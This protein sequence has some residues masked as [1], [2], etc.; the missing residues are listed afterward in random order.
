M[1]TRVRLFSF[2]ALVALVALAFTPAAS[3]ISNDC[4]LKCTPGCPC[5]IEC[6]LVFPTTCGEAGYAC[7]GFA[8]APATD[9][10]LALAEALMTPATEQ[11]LQPQVQDSEESLPALLF[12]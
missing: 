1:S 10:D 5:S 9:A 2:V 3:A 12:R 11:D 4:D 6:T 8:G 7:T